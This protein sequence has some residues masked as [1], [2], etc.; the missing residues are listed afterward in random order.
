MELKK[1]Y[2]GCG[3]D[4]EE[5][6]I[7]IDK[8]ALDG[9]DYIKDAWDIFPEI[10][11]VDEIYS[12]HML[13]HLTSMEADFALRNWFKALKVGGRVHIIVP[14]LDYHCEQWLKAEWNESSLHDKWSDAR[15]GFAGLYGWQK[16]CDP[17]KDNYEQSYWDVHKSGYNEKRIRFLLERIGYD[18]ID[19][20]IVDNVHLVAIAYKSMDPGER[21]IAPTLIGIRKDHKARYEFASNLIDSQAKVL[22]AAC[23][24]GY[25]SFILN[26]QSN[27][28]VLGVD[29]SHEAIA[30][31]K[32]NYGTENVRFEQSDLK[33]LQFEH[34]IFDCIVSF[35]TYE[36]I[37]FTEEFIKS[38]SDLLKANGQLILSTPNEKYL[39]F[40]AE[41]FRFHLKHYTFEDI[42][43]QLERNGFSINQVYSQNYYVCEPEKK[44]L[45]FP[46]GDGEFLITVARKLT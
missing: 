19:I 5:G 28:D 1:I 29:I 46:G 45:I 8:R 27:A 32:K 30:Y 11:D 10:K 33:S 36:H 6:F 14:N 38:C 34:G 31:A 7:H 37:D 24:V 13:E 41:K 43:T 2:V 9:V 42:Q 3:K 23:G 15:Y 16:Q 20:N 40:N 44:G 26:L 22:D 12:R 39:P 35:E 17:T 21:Q 18:S 4:R 25:G